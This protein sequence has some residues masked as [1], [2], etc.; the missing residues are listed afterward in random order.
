MEIL[1]WILA[2]VLLFIGCFL[3]F[4]PEKVL[5]Y[6][7]RQLPNLWDHYHKRDYILNNW[8]NRK[9]ITRFIGILFLL[10][11][12]FVLWSIYNIAYIKFA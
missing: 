6:D 12:L 8:K 11:G 9:R 2:E 5:S 4:F 1:I 10:A 3:S 7:S